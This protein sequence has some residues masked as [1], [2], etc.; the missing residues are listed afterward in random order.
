M[1]MPVTTERNHARNGE[2]RPACE[3]RFGFVWN[4]MTRV[5]AGLGYDVAK[6]K[7]AYNWA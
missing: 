3:G 5:L 1:T 4:E 7:E 2:H 6:R